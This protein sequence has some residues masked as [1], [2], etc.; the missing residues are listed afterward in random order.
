MFSLQVPCHYA[1]IMI[2]VLAPTFVIMVCWLN[3]IRETID[4]TAGH[5][6]CSEYSLGGALS[7]LIGFHYKI[8][9]LVRICLSICFF[10]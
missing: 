8:A 6:K 5:T 9:S 10:F 2:Y 1:I 4:G 3:R 7:H